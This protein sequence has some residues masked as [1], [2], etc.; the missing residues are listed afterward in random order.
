M[1]KHH[2]K[3]HDSSFIEIETCNIIKFISIKEEITCP[4]ELGEQI[5][6]R[7]KLGKTKIKR[8]FGIPF[9]SLG[10][11]TLAKKCFSSAI[12]L[13]CAKSAE[14]HPPKDMKKKQKQKN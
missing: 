5:S 11:D 9:G 14:K 6:C 8:H 4:L 2:Y 7:L 10:Y 13:H 3:S 1:N 12:Q